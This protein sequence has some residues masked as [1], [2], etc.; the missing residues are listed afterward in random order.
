[1]VFPSRGC[2]TCKTR[3]IKCDSVHPVCGRCQKATRTCAWDQNEEAGLL[4]K[5]ENDFA[6]G[7]PRRPWKSKAQAPPEPDVGVDP[8]VSPVLSISKNDETLNF[9]LENYI[10]R[11]AE[12]PEFAR[13]YSYFLVDFL[14][15]V[16]HDSSLYLAMSAFSHAVFG[17]VMQSDKSIEEAERT[18]AR[19]VERVQSE[20]RQAS[21]NN[22]DELLLATM[23]MADYEDVMRN[24]TFHSENEDSLTDLDVTGSRI[25]ED[26]YYDVTASLLRQRQ[27]K[28]WALNTSL[29]RAVR[30]KLI[31]VCIIRGVSVPEWLRDGS[32]FGEEDH[33]LTLDSIMVRVAA[34]RE[35]SLCLFLPKSARF[36]SQP[37][38]GD[39][40][41]EA[42]A[43]DAALESWSAA[44]PEDWKYTTRS[45]LSMGFFDGMI[46]GY[47]TYGHAAIWC[48]YYA[49]CMV[50]NGI[51][52][53]ALS[54]MAQ[55][56]SQMLSVAPEQD[57][58]LQK[59]ESLATDLCR[60]IPAFF[61]ATG[62]PVAAE[63]TR[64]STTACNSQITPKLATLL[65]W[66]LLLAVN[67]D[68]IPQSQVQWLKSK[69]KSIADALGDGSLEAVTEQGGLKF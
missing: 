57:T 35:R 25:W 65:A 31:R 51:R 50:V 36:S 68:F 61:T 46:Y 7:K 47:T 5:D 63:S 22:I 48:R 66:P 54:V 45:V 62:D 26:S 56:S 11:D 59:I 32:Q 41:T 13:E 39:L 8:V 17:R 24:Q 44:L 6:R 67:T 19:G 40:A 28:K 23:L 60:S 34:L 14:P 15:K 37:H 16:Q 3:R 30:R 9:W 52:N 55:C 2:V 18:F 42:R 49:I 27:H 12:I 53:R 1:M 33:V 64:T 29:S 4:F 20:I 21:Q 43:V 38:P 69:F 58:C 10:N